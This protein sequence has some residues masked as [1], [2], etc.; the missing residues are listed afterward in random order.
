M[1]AY[2]IKSS[3]SLLLL[4]GLYWFLLRNEKLFVFNRYYLVFSLIFSLVVPFIHIPVNVR[5][6]ESFRETLLIFKNNIQPVTLSQE[7]LSHGDI[8]NAISGSMDSSFFSL[9]LMLLLIY[10]TGISLFLVRFLRNIYKIIKTI[11]ISE[12][13]QC[14]G[15]R[16]ILTNDNPGPHCFFRNIFLNREDYFNGKIDDDMLNHEMEHIKQGHTFDIILIELIKIFYWFNPIYLLYDRAIRINHEFLADHNVLKNNYNIKN[17]AE[18]LFS[19]IPNSNIPLTS[20]SNQSFTKK[21]LLMMTK[22]KSRLFINRIKIAITACMVAVVLLILGFKMSDKQP[23]EQNSVNVSG[24]KLQNAVRGIVTKEDGS[25]LYL[26][27]I[28]NLTGRG[29]QTGSDGRF[30]LSDIQEGDL[31]NF[32]CIGYKDKI[33]KV[34][35]TSEMVVKMEIDPDY[36]KGVRTLDASYIHEGEYVTIKV[37]DDKMSQA[38]LVIDEEVT[39]YKGEIKL[40]RDEIGAGKVLRGKEAIDKYGEKGKYGVVE[41]IT[42]KRA[43]ELGIKPPEPKPDRMNPEDYPTFQGKSSATFTEWLINNIKYPDEAKKKEIE[44]RVTLNFNVQID[45]SIR[46]ITSVAMPDPILKD[47]VIEA[48]QNSPKWEPAKNPD[49]NNPFPLRVSIKFQLPNQVMKDDVFTVVEK[50]P[51]YPGGEMELRKFIATNMHYPEEARAQRAEGVVMV[52]FVVN[53]EGI[54]EDVEIMKRVH[55]AI[56]AEVLRIVSKL[57]PF[58]HGYQGGKPVNV[59]YMLP[60]TFT[61]NQKQ[62]DNAQEIKDVAIETVNM[63]VLYMG[64][65]NPVEIAVPG[66]TS[67]KV[68]ATAKNGS[69]VRTSDGWEV[70]PFYVGEVVISVLVNNKKVAEKIFRVKPIPPPVAVFAGKND[71]GILKDIALQTKSLNVEL[72]DFLWDLKFE[73]ESFVFYISKDEKDIEISTKGNELTAEMRSLISGC[74]IGKHIVFKDIKAIGPDDRIYDLNPIVLAIR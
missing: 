4:F 70:K 36:R 23:S 30:V 73:I 22:S 59:Y 61:L 40:K 5:D 17:Y 21:R 68:S 10:F 25:P 15:Y 57:E 65:S 42:K 37:T 16:I 47:A 20:G 8:L 54:I 74:K 14:N 27:T 52:R 49:F 66:V 24:E 6:S 13:Q 2:I 1:T 32:S 50:M 18:K 56:D 72:K 26:V 41:I 19:F 53:T 34:N 43:D 71:G 67:D 51:Q 55:P 62:V 28:I 33:V 64:L 46:N 12:K 38:L 11:R 39:D 63:N 44:G 45:G 48:I 58:V 3:I 9:S 7:N 29:I 35:L 60:M 31:L 69:I